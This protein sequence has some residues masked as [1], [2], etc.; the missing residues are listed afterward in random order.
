MAAGMADSTVKVFILSKKQHDILTVDDMVK[1]Q[2]DESLKALKDSL[3]DNTGSQI[4]E[5]KDNKN[6]TP[7]KAGKKSVK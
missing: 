5:K 3:N 6:A 2:I 4:E 1:E 7:S